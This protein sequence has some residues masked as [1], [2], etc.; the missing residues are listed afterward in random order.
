MN[1]SAKYFSP[2]ANVSLAD[3]RDVKGTFGTD[4][5]NKW[6]PWNYQQRLNVVKRVETFKKRVALEKLYEKTKR[7]KITDFVAKQNNRQEFLPLLVSYIN[8]AH[9][10]PL[11]LKKNAWQYFVKAVL[12]EAIRKSKLSADCKKFSE[13]PLDSPFAQVITALQREV[14]TRRLAN[15]TK[16]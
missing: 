4:R 11:H 10:E 16:Q 1:I 6:K 14:K 8:K 15:K 3:C 13:V 7:S 12:T 2:F 9:V 5:S